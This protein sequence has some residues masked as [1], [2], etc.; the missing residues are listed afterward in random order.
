MPNP[1]QPLIEAADIAGQGYTPENA[2]RVQ[3]WYRHLPDAVD[4]ISRMLTAH[5]QKMTD[6]FYLDP[7]AGQYV[8]ELGQQFSRFHEPVRHAADSFTRVHAEDLRRIDNPQPNQERWDIGRN[9]E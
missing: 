2:R 8:A 5:G 4:A 3:D 1:F 6:E 9:R 7:A